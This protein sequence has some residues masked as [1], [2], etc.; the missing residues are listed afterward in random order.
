MIGRGEGYC[1]GYNSPGYANPVPRMG[2]G[3][4]H[5]WGGAWCGRW[6]RGR[7]RC[8]MYYATRLPGWARF[9]YAPAWDAPPDGGCVPYRAP[10]APEQEAEFLRAQADWLKQQVELSSTLQEFDEETSLPPW[11]NP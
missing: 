8:H 5:D 1:A 10:L 3:W 9:G 11:G 6:G 4:R 7:G 2:M